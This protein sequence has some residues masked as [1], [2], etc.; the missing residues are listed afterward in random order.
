MKKRMSRREDYLKLIYSL[1]A[2]GDVHGADL[3]AALN[4]KRPTVCVYLKRLAQNGDITI[5]EHHCA[6][7]TEQGLAVALS[8]LDKHGLL[9]ALLQQIGVPVAIAKKDACAIEHCISP[10]TYGALK[11]VLNERQ[12]KL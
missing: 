11:Q 5:D 1:S 8:T 3:A 12:I 6:C 2:S 4:I 10:E 9:V 7:L